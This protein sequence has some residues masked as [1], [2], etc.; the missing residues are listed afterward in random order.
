MAG[1][2]NETFKNMATANSHKATGPQGE[3]K[4]KAAL[5]GPSVMGTAS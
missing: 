5:P 2:T 1:Q 4:G 3:R